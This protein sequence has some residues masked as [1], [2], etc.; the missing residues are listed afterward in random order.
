MIIGMVLFP[1]LT[2]LDLTGPYEVFGRLPSTQVLLIAENNT[3]VKADNGLLLTPDC[4]F[5]T[6]PQ[7]DILFVPGGRGIFE[8]MQQAPLIHFLQQQAIKASYIT[9]VCTGSLVLAAAGLLDGYKATTHWL[10]L[11]LL[12]MFKVEVI[13]D[14]VVIDR[15][16]ITGGGVTAGIDFGLTIAAKL[17]GGDTAK[18]IQLMMEYNPAPPFNSGSPA[19]ADAAMVQKAIT[20]RAAIQNERAALI[21][22]LFL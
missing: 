11:N 20:D 13:E 16:R 6:A 3:A 7:V 1:N 4:T 19:T 18:E 8:A 12:A 17:F 14:R 15:N 9:S 21:K 5:T 22:K 2:Q 10:S